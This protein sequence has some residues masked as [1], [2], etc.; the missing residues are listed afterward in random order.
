MTR[1]MEW[2]IRRLGNTVRKRRKEGG[3]RW[4]GD[5]RGGGGRKEGGERW[6]GDRRGGEGGGRAKI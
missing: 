6:G 2:I 1:Q 5:R 3:E 4:S